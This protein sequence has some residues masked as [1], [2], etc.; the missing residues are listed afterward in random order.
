MRKKKRSISQQQNLAGWAFLAPTVVLLLLFLFYPMLKGLVLSLSGKNGFT[1]VNYQRIVQDPTFV[2]AIKNTLYY[3]AIEILLMLPLALLLATILQQKNLKFRNTYRVLLFVPCCMAMMS[4]A[5]V[6]KVMFGNNGLVN[7]LLTRWGILQEPYPFLSTTT[8]ARL[9]IT[10]C[11]VWRWTGYN[12][13]FYCTGFGNIDPQIYE[14]AELDGASAVQKFFR[15]T[16]PLLKPII[17]LTI[18]TTTNGTLQILDEI[19]QLTEG[20]PA[21]STISIS[22]YIYNTA[23]KGT[24]K[25]GYASAMSFVLF[26]AIALLTAVQMKVGDKRD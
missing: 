21:N 18:I 2:K 14:A 12:M 10:I 25:F 22:M 7:A 13:V 11:L 1:L 17:L 9:V 8:G 20:G 16:I 24:P 6:F 23:F 15:I 19:N 26:V 3:V 5:T 4:Y